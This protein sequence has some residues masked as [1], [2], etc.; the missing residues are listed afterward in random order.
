M[1]QLLTSAGKIIEA[2]GDICTGWLGVYLDD[3]RTPG[4]IRIKN[5]TPGGPAAKAGLEPE[6]V[7]V[8]WNGAAIPVG[9]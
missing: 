7:L 6:D 3:A 1:S 9:K 8:K 5:V 2:G 4:G